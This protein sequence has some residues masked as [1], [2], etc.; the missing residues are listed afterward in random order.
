M[1]SPRDKTY[2][3]AVH[4]A[5]AGLVAADDPLVPVAWSVQEW[6]E[7]DSTLNGVGRPSVSCSIVI[8]PKVIII[9]AIANKEPPKEAA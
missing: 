3:K 1:G 8:F 2:Y 6:A 5:I 7:Q 9:I 4:S